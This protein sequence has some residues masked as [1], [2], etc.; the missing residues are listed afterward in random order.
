[1]GE[2]SLSALEEYAELEKRHDFLAAQ[3]LDL[4][5]SV[6]S[7]QSAITRINRTTREL[8][9]K[10]FDEVNAKFTETFPKFFTGGRAE[11]RITGE[12]DI[13]E[14]GVDIVAQPPGKKLQNI[15]LSC[16]AERR[17]L[18]L[19]PSYSRYSS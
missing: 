18:P 10:T 7:L 16:P 17:P 2:V 5:K 11:L 4:D 19:L 14:C 9:Q 13:L 6:E 12:G 8:F 15:N 1:M 3:Q